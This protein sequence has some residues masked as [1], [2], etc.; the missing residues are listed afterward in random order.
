ME[1]CYTFLGLGRVIPSASVC[2]P[3]PLNLSLLRVNS[4][5][6]IS[7]YINISYYHYLAIYMYFNDTFF[8]FFMFNL[9]VY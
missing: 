4:L 7:Y 2:P 8:K 1:S 5:F 9:N 6:L 3:P